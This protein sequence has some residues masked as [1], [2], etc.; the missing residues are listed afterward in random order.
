LPALLLLGL[1]PALLAS[2]CG[3]SRSSSG[4]VV[5]PAACLAFTPAADPAPSTVVARR[6]SA[7]TCDRLALELIITDVSDLFI[8]D[9]RLSF[10]PAVLS[11]AGYDKT[12]SVLESDGETAWVLLDEENGA[13]QFTI[14][15]FG[16]SQDGIDVVGSQLLVRIDFLR[17]ADTGVSPL[18]FSGERL[19]NSAW[20]LELIDGVEWFGGSVT[21][22]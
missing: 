18:S 20:P 1:V 7:T 10:D 16:S 19:W 17:E 22:R 15:R 12:G 8:A 3:G 21:V 11:Y 4:G 2:S 5:E 13:I 9:F 14:S 6:G